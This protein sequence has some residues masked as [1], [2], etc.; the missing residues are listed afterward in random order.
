MTFTA[1]RPC[2][3]GANGRL[4]VLLEGLSVAQIPALY[5]RIG[6]GED[7][8]TREGFLQ[9]SP[10]CFPPRGK[11]MT[12]C[13]GSD[14]EN[15]WQTGPGKTLENQLLVQVELLEDARITS[16]RSTC[17]QPKIS[18]LLAGDSAQNGADQLLVSA[19]LDEKIDNE[20]LTHRGSLGGGRFRTGRLHLRQ[21]TP[22]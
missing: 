21:S 11:T 18:V 9:P 8:A 13:V 19:V 6:H 12:V 20:F 1:I 10:D 16:S 7:C 5:V 14:D 3:G 17:P 22:W 15:V 2:S 4:R